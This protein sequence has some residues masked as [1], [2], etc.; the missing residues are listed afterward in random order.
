MLIESAVA[1][2]GA[3]M[4]RGMVAPEVCQALLKQLWSDLCQKDVQTCYPDNDI[5]LKPALEI[6]G[7]D[8]IPIAHFHW[9]VTSAVSE[10]TGADLLPSFSYFRMY[11]GGDICRIH[12]DR[13]A[14]EV[15]LS[16]TL[17]YGDDKPWP[18]S[19]ATTPVARPGMM[20]L[21]D[22]FGDEPFATFIMQPG[23]AVLYA[24]STHRHGRI[25]P[26]PNE[27]SA[28]LFL[29]WVTRDGPNQQ[30]AFERSARR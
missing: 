12:S 29:Q 10:M 7:D 14:S 18:F 2:S 22:E 6:H 8:Y 13:P 30:W 9:G 5:L 24:G 26:N 16:V 28:H 1:A 17:A 15:S 3:C 19:V 25:E 4:L 27:W 21:S 11:V 23:D 20:N